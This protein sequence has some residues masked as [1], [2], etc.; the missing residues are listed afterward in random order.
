MKTSLDSIRQA[1]L[2][3]EESNQKIGVAID[4][5]QKKVDD[6]VIYYEKL[7]QAAKKP[8][9]VLGITFLVGIFLGQI[10]RI[11]YK[12]GPENSPDLNELANLS[13]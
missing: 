3:V 6:G 5:L 2:E 1:E 12:K 11:S 4:H 13:S 9:A 8:A 10:L 7:S